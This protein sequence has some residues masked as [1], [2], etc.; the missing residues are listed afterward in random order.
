MCRTI[1]F[2]TQIELFPYSLD[3]TTLRERFTT[4]FKCLAQQ[5]VKS[6]SPEADHHLLLGNTLDSGQMLTRDKSYAENASELYLC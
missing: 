1:C 5:K 6:L 2:T 4:K 3:K